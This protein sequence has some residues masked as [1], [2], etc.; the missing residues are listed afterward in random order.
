[1]TYP[2]EESTPNAFDEWFQSERGTEIEYELETDVDECE[3]D[4]YSDD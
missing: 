4:D 2:E 1:M 3:E